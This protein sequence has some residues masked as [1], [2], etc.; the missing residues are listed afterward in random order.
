MIAHESTLYELDGA[1]YHKLLLM[2]YK[3]TSRRGARPADNLDRAK[4]I[5]LRQYRYIRFLK[6]DWIKRLRMP[7]LPYPKRQPR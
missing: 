4:Q 6:T 2:A 7:V 3:L 1:V 5:S